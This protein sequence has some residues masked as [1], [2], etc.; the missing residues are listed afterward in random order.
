MEI[1]RDRI[2]VN[3]TKTEKKIIENFMN[4]SEQFSNICNKESLKRLCDNCPF[5]TFCNTS[6]NTA[7]DIEDFINRQINL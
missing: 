7:D 2:K 3:F 5:Q 1:I 6:F 4:L